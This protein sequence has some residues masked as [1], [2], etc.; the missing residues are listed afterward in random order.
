MPRSHNIARTTR[1]A[2]EPSATERVF[3]T[4]PL[5][6]LVDRSKDVS[7]DSGVLNLAPSSIFMTTENRRRL[8]ARV[9][10]RYDM[11]AICANSATGYTKDELAAIRAFVHR[12][13]GLV[14]AACSGAFEQNTGRSVEKLSANAVGGMFGFTFLSAQALPADENACCGFGR[15]RLAV[16]IRGKKLGLSLGDIPLGRPGPLAAPKDARVL[17]RERSPGQAVAA[18]ARYGH[19]RVLA[20]NDL[21]MWHAWNSWCAAHWIL[22]A[23]P[24][25]RK[26]TT[27][28]RSSAAH[29]VDIIPVP[30]GSTQGKDIVV[31]HTASTRRR[32]GKVMK[33]AGRVRQELFAVLK[34]AKRPRLW[35]ITIEPGCSSWMQWG[36]DEEVRC[37]VGCDR[38]DASLV[39]ALARHVG[40]RLWASMHGF[41]LEAFFEGTVRY[42]QIRVLEKMGFSEAG[43]ELRRAPCRRRR[44]DLGRAYSETIRDNEVTGLWIAIER[45]FGEKAFARFARVVPKKEKPFEGISREVF[46]DFDI[47]AYL[48][49]RALGERVY[50]WLQTQ[51]HTLRRIPLEAPKSRELKRAIDRDLRGLLGDPGEAPSDRFD[52]AIA[53]AGRLSEDKVGLDRCAHVAKSRCLGSAFP[54][55]TRLL[56]AKDERGAGALHRLARTADDG[57]A[58][59][60]ALLLVFEAGDRDAA[61]LLVRVARRYDTRF[62][63]SAGHALRIA[64]D[65]RAARFSFSRIKGCRVRT[66]TDGIVKVFPMV[67]GFEVANTWGAPHFQPQPYGSAHSVFY[68]YWVHTSPRWRRRGLARL[69]MDAFLHHR[70]SRQCAATEL[71]TNTRWVAHALYRSFELID[72]HVGVLFQKTLLKERAVRVPTGF[73]L[74][75]ATFGDSSSASAF[76]NDELAAGPAGHQGRQRLDLAHWS[77][78]AWL[79][80]QGGRLVGLACARVTGRTA[81]LDRVVVAKIKDKK[82]RDDDKRRRLLGRSLLGALHRDLARRNVR[83]ASMA[84]YNGRDDYL[85]WLLRAGGYSSGPSGGVGLI[86]IDDLVRYLGE[87]ASVFEHRLRE[88]ETWATWRG[89]ICLDGGRL[90]ACLVIS[91]GRVAVTERAAAKPSITLSGSDSAVTRIVVGIAT[92]FEEYLQATLKARPSLNDR[93]RDLLETLFPRMIRE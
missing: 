90:R 19:G 73:R 80:Y 77:S 30:Y 43:H 82:D 5:A 50:S 38:S 24:R 39:S 62:Q 53:L 66:V 49:A 16:T 68:I 59:A 28:N 2:R 56:L 27:E 7:E 3:A 72:R 20:C 41:R 86:R 89:S 45:E 57:L 60:A 46:T 79:A 6:I 84:W 29:P 85:F 17:L 71:H 61:D 9:L 11:L 91:K 92:P 81:R 76:V 78:V 14:L 13:G 52:A 42:L 40:S 54:A 51:G 65:R 26:T 83:E 4:K 67:D 75:R 15:T 47:L 1:S 23:A 37:H 22:A 35:R 36:P 21:A 87:T 34:P 12:G 10:E 88:S 25:R 32:V 58:A 31:Y 48:L 74:R 64:G 93:T 69:G 33:L 8:T 63:L 55:A 18:V 44:V 70:W